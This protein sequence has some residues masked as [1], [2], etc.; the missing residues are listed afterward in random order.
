MKVRHKLVAATAALGLAV[1]A[2]GP[3]QA[4][5]IPTTWN[6]GTKMYYS[7]SDSSNL[8]CIQKGSS[9]PSRI[10][11]DFYSTTSS[12]SRRGLEVYVGN[13]VCVDPAV[14]GWKENQTV[15]FRLHNSLGAQS[16]G[17]FTT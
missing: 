1:A 2:A 6:G 11:V 14:W 8:F 15:A 10:S 3:A 12:H 9:S 13:K 7:Y 17:S 5:T 4:S 16:R